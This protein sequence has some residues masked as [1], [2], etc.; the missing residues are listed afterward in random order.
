MASSRANWTFAGS[1]CATATSFV[2]PGPSESSTPTQ[3]A[4]RGTASCAIFASASTESF[5]S[6]SCCVAFARNVRR[7]SSRFSCVASR[8]T[9]TTPSILPS[10]SRIGAALSSIGIS[11]PS[12]RRNTVW[13]ARSTTLPSRN[14]LSTGFS[15]TTPVSSLLIGKI[16]TSLR[17]SASRAVQPVSRSATGFMNLTVPVASVEITASPLPRELAPARG[18]CIR[19]ALG[20]GRPHDRVRCLD[21][22]AVRT[23]GEVAGDLREADVLAARIAQRRD[24]R[25]RPE[26]RAVLAVA[27][28]DALDPALGKR[29]LE[30][31]DR[32]ARRAILLRADA[33][34]AHAD[35]LL[36]RVA[37]QPLGT[38]VPR[39]DRAVRRE[40]VDRV[41][42]D[43][44]D[45]EAKR[46]SWRLHGVGSVQCA[47]TGTGGVRGPWDF[48]R[49]S[50]PPRSRAS[51]RAGG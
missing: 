18:V 20:V 3:S 2:L 50:R 13:F 19:P 42:L 25:A 8:N 32:L 14:T 6:A 1:T 37:L 30:Q 9:S 46:F 35:D 21:E 38:R 45:E 51:V 11:T 33:G 24:E 36:A 28:A 43:R 5:A 12:R 29:A 26:L 31:A 7:N 23:V 4:R 39:L 40:Q 17:P 44:I 34:A 49:R 10:G 16:S 41:V 15:T 48:R 47:M 22:R 27:P